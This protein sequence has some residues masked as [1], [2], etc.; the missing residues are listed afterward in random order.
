M[1][2]L[3][4]RT[5]VRYADGEVS[6]RVRR[7]VVEH[8]LECPRCRAT[9]DVLGLVRASASSP[10]SSSDV[11]LTGAVER[12]AAGERVLL[13]T[14]GFG[15]PR[16]WWRV[17]ALASAGAAATLA[18]SLVP[19]GRTGSDQA[20]THEEDCMSGMRSAFYAIVV[21]S[22]V[23]CADAPTAFEL[24]D[25]A[26]QPVTSLAP[27]RIATG[28]YVY[29]DVMWT[30]GLVAS[31]QRHTEY[32]LRPTTVGGSS[33]WEVRASYAYRFVAGR[34]AR[35][36]NTEVAWFDRASLAPVRSIAYAPDGRPWIEWEA[37]SDSII[38]RWGPAGSLS[39]RAARPRHPGIATLGITGAHLFA[40]LVSLPLTDGW[41][42]QIGA[43]PYVVVGQEEVTVPAGTF[44]CWRL[45]S[46]D[47]GERRGRWTR[48][49]RAW[50]AVDQPLVVRYEFGAVPD[51]RETVLVSFDPAGR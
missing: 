22:G 29:E 4:E 11:L 6:E 19:A 35:T 44:I 21:G 46:P 9:V 43:L 20:P 30:D 23:A 3:R 48:D 49:V 18:V 13:P 40:V 31:P 7:T 36:G 41:G 17:A 5:L 51:R 24:P 47:R 8:L 50:V 42:G 14:A 39:R 2:H 37:T 10:P 38:Q 34:Y 27:N 45:E 28:T 25:S 15:F 33:V 12:R 32:T 26:Y 16:R 1:A